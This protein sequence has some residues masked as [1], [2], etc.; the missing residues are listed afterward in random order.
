M[1]N[2]ENATNGRRRL[3]ELIDEQNAFLIRQKAT[4]G[5]VRETKVHSEM[6]RK[7]K[8]EIPLKH[9]EFRRVWSL[10]RKP[11]TRELSRRP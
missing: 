11:I 1:K 7:E 3:Q 9:C 4:I 5:S 6:T 10:W 2:N 8:L